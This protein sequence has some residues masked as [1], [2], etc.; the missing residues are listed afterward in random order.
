MITVNLI[1]TTT[2][3][4]IDAEA[5]PIHVYMGKNALIT[6]RDVVALARLTGEQGGMN[7][8]STDNRR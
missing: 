3:I 4:F 5:I 6:K 2:P 1:A 7:E 8:N